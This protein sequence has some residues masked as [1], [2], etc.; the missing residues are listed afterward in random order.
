MLLIETQLLPPSFVYIEAIRQ[1]G[2]L[3]EANEN[4]QKKSLRNRFFTV[5]SKSSELSSVPL[6]KGKA[7]QKPIQEVKISYSENWQAKIEHRLNTA[8]GSAPYFLEYI[9]SLIN[10]LK[11]R[12]I[13]LYELNMNLL[14]WTLEVVNIELELQQTK[15][16]HSVYPDDVLDWRNKGLP[17]Y[18]D[19]SRD[20]LTYDQVF[21]DRLGFIC[22]LSI[23]DLLFNLGPETGI[24]LHNAS[25]S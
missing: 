6:E 24:F 14:E 3:I 8:Y 18:L 21:E 13:H 2:W 12:F 17:F 4:Y 16:Y 5:S 19:K 1:G 7:N 15:S 22:N 10:I 20:V 9:D 23:I 11:Q 25:K